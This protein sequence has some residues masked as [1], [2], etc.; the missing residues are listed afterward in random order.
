[1]GGDLNEKID[2]EGKKAILLTIITKFSK[3]YSDLIL[4]RNCVS[5]S[6]ELLGGARINY[7]FNDVFRK[8]ILSINP[9]KFITDD[10]IRVAIRNA[11][12]LNPS[13]L[14]SEAAFEMLVRDQIGNFVFN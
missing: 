12:G 13:L 10:R 2:K 11:N 5:E 6:G 1:M 8:K 7:V 3:K 14:V 4:G 9:F